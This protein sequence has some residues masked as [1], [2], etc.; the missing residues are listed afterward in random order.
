MNRKKK[1]IQ[2]S[3]LGVRL[4]NQKASWNQYSAII[5]NKSMNDILNF[6]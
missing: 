1:K 3:L 5:V 2:K 6:I 4:A